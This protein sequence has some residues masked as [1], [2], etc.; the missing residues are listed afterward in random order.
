MKIEI[1]KTIKGYD[2][3]VVSNRGYVKNIITHHIL[4]NL[5]V[6]QKRKYYAVCLYNSEGKKWFNVARLVATAFIPNP[7]NLPEV[8]HISGNSRDNH[9]SNLRWMSHKEN[10]RAAW[11]SGRF[12]R[13][14]W[15][16][17][18][19]ITKA[20]E[21]RRLKRK[22][23]YLT[24]GQ[25]GLLYGICASAVYKIINH[26]TFKENMK[27]QKKRIK[28]WEDSLTNDTLK[29]QIKELRQIFDDQYVNSLKP[30]VVKKSKEIIRTVDNKKQ[31]V[32]VPNTNE[33]I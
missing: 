23:P 19:N 17:R 5:R 15:K 21:I 14:G 27:K 8:D 33:T 20:R 25:I 26:R 22:E 12:K 1:W 32:I 29:K 13:F 24:N 10:I 6:S 28:Y 3:Y 9:S 18:L 2:R 4:K 16:T 31:P 30:K 11:N 7:L